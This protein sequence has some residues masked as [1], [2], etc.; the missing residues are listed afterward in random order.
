MQRKLC[1]VAG[2]F[3]ILTIVAGVMHL[4]S[5]TVAAQ[6]SIATTPV[7]TTAQTAFGMISVNQSTGAISFCANNSIVPNGGGGQE[8]IGTCSAS[9]IGSVTPTAGSDNSL[10]IQGSGGV[11]N[12]SGSAALVY[13]NQTGQ[14]VLC[15]GSG[16]VSGSVANV[17]ASC[18]SVSNLH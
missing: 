5:F 10:S 3:G 4:S 7:F 11:A 6:G 18:K 17:V 14:A 16:V 13:N 1:F 2:I 15:A 12:G 8:P 9:S